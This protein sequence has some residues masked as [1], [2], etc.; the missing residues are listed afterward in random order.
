MAKRKTQSNSTVNAVTNPK[1]DDAAAHREVERRQPAVGVSR[2]REQYSIIPVAV[3]VAVSLNSLANGFAADDLQQVLSNPLIKDLGNIPSAFTSSVWTF[4][5]ENIIFTTDQYYR[6]IFNVFLTINYAIFGTSA[7]G[8][9]LSNIAIDALVAYLVFALMR[10][11]AGSPWIAL[12][13]ALLFAAHPIHAESIAWISGD[14]DPLMAVFVLP[15]FLLYLT[16][17]RERTWLSLAGFLILFF[18]GLLCKETALV[19]PILILYCEIWHFGEIPIR[20]RATN[21]ARLLGWMAIPIAIY[22]LMR[23]YVLGALVLNGGGHLGI[24]AALL[25]L[26]QILMDYVRLTFV[27]AGYSYMHVVG[28]VTSIASAAVWGSV[29]LLA[30]LATLII[31]T[32]SK[33]VWFGAVFFVLWLAPALAA[34]R[35]FDPEFRVQE[36]YLYLSSA[37]ACLIVVLAIGWIRNRE[38]LGS[39]RHAVAGV[40]IA[41]IMVV[42]LV[43]HVRQN[44]VW[45]DN[46]SLYQN[47]VVQDPT[48]TAARSTL[49][50]V[51]VE[52]GRVKEG[53]A[54]LR[55]A[56]DL[57]PKSPDPYVSLSSIANSQGHYDRAIS[58]LQ[59]GLRAV[60]QDPDTT[61]KLAT[62]YLNLGFLYER[63]KDF[64]RAENAMQQ[65]IQIWRRPVGLYY[66]GQL[67]VDE[68]R[69]PQALAAYQQAMGL[70]SRKF[71]PIHM[72]LAHVYE[73]LG[74]KENARLE[75]EQFIKLTPDADARSDAQRRLSQL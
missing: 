12:G 63:Q 58:Y 14:T 1:M 56:L 29:V 40:A 9:H 16:F 69:Y 51:Y 68:G 5:S 74:D 32:R 46:T 17:R 61:Q 38:S 47:C 48:L 19:L 41:A 10:R 42:F 3:A 31:L 72:K 2:W 26:P 60:P 33:N 64:D 73:E 18:F 23:N 45:A 54:E 25:M 59:D 22:L 75:Y 36:R 7:W 30:G 65:S 37:G 27:P 55:R 66:L 70:L 49:G 67:Y 13:T 6:P 24:R 53:E 28:L 43:T 15:A 35:G 71:G 52:A 20:E 57:D 50:N 34:I 39:W 62:M 44:T 4:S 8:W 21:A 11:I